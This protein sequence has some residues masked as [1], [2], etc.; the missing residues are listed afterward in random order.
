VSSLTLV[1]GLYWTAIKPEYRNFVSGGEAT[2]AVVA[3][4]GEALQDIVELVEQVDSA[5][6]EKAADELAHRFAGI[7]MFS[8]VV[9]YVPSV[10]DHEWGKLWLDAISRP[11]MP[12][13]F[14]PDKA[15]IDES[16][17]TNYYTGLGLAGFAQG[18][19]ISMGYIADSY[20][21]F[22]EIGMMG[23]LL[24]FGFFLGYIYRWFLHHPNGY[25]LLACG[26]ASSTLIQAA[27]IGAS[28]A[29]LFGGIVVSV[30]VAMV[31]LNFIF[32]RYLSSL[33]SL[34]HDVRSSGLKRR[35]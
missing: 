22:G 6:L 2:Q 34:D 15:V 12:R 5:K 19:Q 4:Y 18:T 23:A 35:P 20:I 1:F 24:G 16:T 11:F 21:D 17:L 32:A 25:G 3:G 27:E 8:A 26:L 30:L 33:Q 14:F 9:A 28:S 10:R 13:M 29:K 7:D 31:F